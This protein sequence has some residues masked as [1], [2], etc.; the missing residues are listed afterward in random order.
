MRE[1][2]RQCLAARA[3]LFTVALAAIAVRRSGATVEDWALVAR[4]LLDLDGEGHLEGAAAIAERCLARARADA[5]DD[6]EIKRLG[7]EVAERLKDA[8]PPRGAL[9]S[10]D[11]IV[12]RLFD[13][14]ES[15]PGAPAETFLDVPPDTQDVVVTE[16]GDE[17]E[18]RTAVLVAAILRADGS[19]ALHAF[20]LDSIAPWAANPEVRDAVEELSD[21]GRRALVEP[22]IGEALRVIDGARDASLRYQPSAGRAARR[23]GTAQASGARG[24]VFS[25]MAYRHRNILRLSIVAALAI[26]SL[27]AFVVIFLGNEAEFRVA[28]MATG[29][30][31]LGLGA[32]TIVWARAV[33]VP[34]R[35]IVGAGGARFEVVDG[36]RPKRL[37]FPLDYRAAL[38]RISISDD[39]RDREVVH[40]RLVITDRE[41]RA[42]V[43]FEE[44]LGELETPP[45]GWAEDVI[46]LPPDITYG[47]AFGRIHLDRLE[48][49][50]ARWN[51]ESGG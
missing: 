38:E 3:P 51:R 10:A 26:M 4:A 17:G 34:Y 14:I 41:G 43:A 2:A 35:I 18:P 48:R 6:A 8:P 16:I 33:R 28:L 46:G 24:E 36:S 25:G 32:I 27:I 19:P 7:A 21:S 13:A 5:P 11:E 30:A 42:A 9:P 29:A 50:I 20:L 12:A 37:P 39:H 45:R 15:A 40:L 1:A 22:S 44:R 47:R 23:S 49:E 31:A